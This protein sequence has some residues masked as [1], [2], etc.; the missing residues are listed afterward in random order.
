MN[1]EQGICREIRD[2]VMV[3]R[4]DRAS[5]RN[6][7]TVSM[8]AA[9]ADGL[10]QAATDN[11]VRVVVLTGSTEAFT[12]G[13]DLKDFRDNPPQGADAP[14]HRFLRALLAFPK[15][16]IASVCGPAVGVGTTMLLH[17]DLIY[18]GENATLVLPFV[19]LGLCPEAGSSV[20]L[21]ALA[22][23]QR[24]AEKL[25]FGEPFDAREAQAMGLVNRVLPAAEVEP[26]AL[27]RAAELAARPLSALIAT[28]AL[29]KQGGADAV[30]QAMKR[31]GEQFGR[32]LRSPAAREAFSAFLEKR[33]PDFARVEREADDA[34]K[35]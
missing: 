2:S 30:A 35:G 6:A 13:N 7:I 14:V 19:N 26:H 21:P 11:T 17:C 33:K 34:A 15:P 18:A 22:G 29:M 27:A 1:E 32:L 25:L 31:E 3:L 5:R 9:L 12:A 10:E 4:F 24:A 8:Y 20:L 28:K 16:L 23:H